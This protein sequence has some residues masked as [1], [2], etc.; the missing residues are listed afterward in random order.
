M[1]HDYSRNGRHTFG[2][3]KQRKGTKL[4]SFIFGSALMAK[5]LVSP[6]LANEGTIWL[7]S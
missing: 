6:R 5:S 1:M 7:A 2:I 3:I 4:D